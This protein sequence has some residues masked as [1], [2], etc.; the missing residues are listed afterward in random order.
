MD[1][2][3]LVRVACIGNLILFSVRGIGFV[4]MRCWDLRF[5]ARYIAGQGFRLNLQVFLGI[6]GC[7]L[8]CLGTR[9]LFAN[10]SASC[11]HWDWRKSRRHL[12][13]A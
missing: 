2:F 12:N 8:F 3:D 4:D 1:E 7:R 13:A 6:P 10:W 11:G 5:A 9:F